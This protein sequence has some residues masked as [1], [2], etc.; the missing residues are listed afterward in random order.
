MFLTFLFKHNKKMT[1]TKKLDLTLII[2]GLAI[3][4]INFY[5]I[6]DVYFIS[7]LTHGMNSIEKLSTKE[8][9][10]KRLVLIVA[11]GLRSDSFFNLIDNDKSLFLR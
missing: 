7:P 4:L 2:I 1:N 6:F 9:P 5:S 11:D 3:H 8:S 10:A